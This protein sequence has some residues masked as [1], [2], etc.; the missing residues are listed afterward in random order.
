MAALPFT[1]LQ[2]DLRPGDLAAGALEEHRDSFASDDDI[3]VLNGA[4]TDAIDNLTRWSTKYSA[5]CT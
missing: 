3:G 4:F 1:S 2:V 5:H